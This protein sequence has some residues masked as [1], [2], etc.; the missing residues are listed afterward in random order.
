MCPNHP[1]PP[2][3]RFFGLNPLKLLTVLDAGD[4]SVPMIPGWT[5]TGI[6]GRG[7]FGTVWRAQ[8]DSDGAVAA[9]KIAPASEPDTLERIEDEIGALRS[10]NHPQIVSLLDS[11]P[12]DD[13]EGGLFLAMEFIDGA[14]LSQEIPSGGLPPETAYTLFRQISDAVAHAHE[15]GILHRDLKPANIL[16]DPDGRA[17]V[18]DFGL[19]LPV[20]RRVQQL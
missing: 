12:L 2:P 11:G 16:L 7:G 9:I 15:A 4:Q 18:A 8:R 3:K 17:K 13:P 5:I 6:A 19:A 10:L 14:E 1:D 20:H